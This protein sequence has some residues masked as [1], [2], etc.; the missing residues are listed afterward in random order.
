[1]IRTIPEASRGVVAGLGVM[2]SHHLRVLNAQ[3]DADVVAMVDPSAERRAAAE[4]L[5]PGAVAYATLGE[6]LAAHELD[7]ACI[8]APVRQLPEL[9]HQALAAGL[10]VLVE[11]PLAPDEDAARALIRDAAQR[12]ALLAVD[13]V[14]R[15]NPA[16]VALREK[17]AE[18]L[19]GSI[20]QMHA[21]RLSPFPQRDQMVGVAI[22][23]AT[24]DIDLMRYLTGEEVG[25]VFAESARRVHDTAE[26]LIC[27]TLRFDG[28]ITG[29]LEVN[30][31][32]PTKVREMTVTGEG[33]MFV[34]NYH[35]QDLY[36]Y[37]NPHANVEWEAL[38]G[39]R[40]PGEGNMIRY[41]FDRRE[42]LAVQWE[43]FLL[44]LRNAGEPPVSASDGFAAL[45][46]ARAVQRSGDAHEVVVPGYRDD[47]A[48]VV[49]SVSIKQAARAS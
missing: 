15:F 47:L 35:S 7:F 42:P 8:A 10:A 48:G 23:L 19:I 31:L 49:T 43:A 1:M 44:A 9:A 24:H 34:V 13:H 18:G 40:G 30:W 38:A 5:A 14:E 37:E 22:D 12:G 46:I 21:R 33:G 32:T 25:R 45:S 2:G 27:A 17:L 6:A 3:P 39:V 26:D 36:F 16:V 11:K 4:R 29:L 28:G 41:A 20:H